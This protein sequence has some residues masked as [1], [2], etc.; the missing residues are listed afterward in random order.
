M[1]DGHLGM[2]SLLRCALFAVTLSLFVESRRMASGSLLLHQITFFVVTVS[3][4]LSGKGNINVWGYLTTEMVISLWA[5]CRFCCRR[6]DIFHQSV[7]FRGWGIIM[8]I[9]GSLSRNGYNY[10][11]IASIKLMSIV[12][13]H[14]T[15]LKEVAAP[16][17]FYLK[18]VRL[19]IVAQ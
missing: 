14:K 5:T 1:V 19:Q 6:Q 4:I 11:L 9:C 13:Q 2:C 16:H 18:D 17:I 7:H 15:S 3:I 8:K 12:Q 10:P